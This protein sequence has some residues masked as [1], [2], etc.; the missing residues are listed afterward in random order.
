M[1]ARLEAEKN[2]LFSLLENTRADREKLGCSAFFLLSNSF[3]PFERLPNMAHAQARALSTG[4]GAR[5]TP[6]AA[7]QR[8]AAVAP[9]AS[10]SSSS[11][12]SSSSTRRRKLQSPRKARS[13]SSPVSSPASSSA[14][15]ASADSSASSS[16][17]SSAS[18][19]ASA[20]AAPS[21]SRRSRAGRATYAPAT[22]DE[23]VDDAS[24]ALLAAL[25]DGLKRIEVEFPALPGDKD[26]GCF[27]FQ[28]KRNVLFSLAFDN[29]GELNWDSMSRKGEVELTILGS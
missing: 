8:T 4:V 18:A 25:D 26:G 6:A 16:S 17:S 27:I 15:A 5:T 12:T 21:P 29:V 28:L 13:S 14:A 22:F 10:S 1:R 7:A 2:L 3:T 9:V 23:L 19:S 11:S 20:S 24:A